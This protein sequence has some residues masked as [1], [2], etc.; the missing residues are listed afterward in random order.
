MSV[1]ISSFVRGNITKN[2]LGKREAEFIGEEVSSPL[3]K[4]VI[5]KSYHEAGETISPIF[6]RQKSVGTYRFILNLKS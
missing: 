1:N 2:L 4:G 6:L 3:K 5:V